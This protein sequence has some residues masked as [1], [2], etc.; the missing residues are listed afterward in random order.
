MTKGYSAPDILGKDHG[1]GHGV[2]IG[3][4]DDKYVFFIA[5]TLG[6]DGQ[7][8]QSQFLW[9]PDKAVEIAKSIIEAAD[10]AV[11]KIVRPGE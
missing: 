8:F 4:T 11:S 10:R 9:K 7:P 1:Y 6:P 2:K 3:F 5:D